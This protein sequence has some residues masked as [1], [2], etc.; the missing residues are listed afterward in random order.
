MLDVVSS[1]PCDS[2]VKMIRGDD[3]YL[4]SFLLDIVDY[5]TACLM[6]IVCKRWWVLVD[7]SNLFV[8]LCFM[9][10]VYVWVC[11]CVCVCG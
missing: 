4:F 6:R 10:W 7:V 5:G 3:V 9:G 8:L 1:V 2:I 11:G